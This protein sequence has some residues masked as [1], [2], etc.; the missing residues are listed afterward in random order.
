MRLFRN[1][2]KI[3]KNV[4]ILFD[5]KFYKGG[6]GDGGDYKVLHHHVLNSIL[7]IFCCRYGI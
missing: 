4:T 6:G 3:H 2:K 1:S 5:N 7:E